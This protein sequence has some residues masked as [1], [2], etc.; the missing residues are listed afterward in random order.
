MSTAL[1][2][3]SAQ[4]CAARNRLTELRRVILHKT[5]RA[6]AVEWDWGRYK[7]TNHYYHHRR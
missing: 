2:G 6:G 3:E 4:Y 1:T 5:R 7:A